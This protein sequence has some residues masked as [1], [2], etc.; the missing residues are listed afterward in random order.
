MDYFEQ[1][2]KLFPNEEYNTIIKSQICA[3]DCRNSNAEQKAETSKL[4]H[5]FNR[6]EA[7]GNRTSGPSPSETKENGNCVRKATKDAKSINNRQEKNRRK[8]SDWGDDDDT[9]VIRKLILIKELFFKLI[10]LTLL[11]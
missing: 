4:P 10:I 5:L 3:L 8:M 2:N 1:L 6:K 11:R 9:E 7:I